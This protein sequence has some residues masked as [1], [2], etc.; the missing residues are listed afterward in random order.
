VKRVAVGMKFVAGTVRG[1]PFSTMAPF[2]LPRYFPK[3]AG[4]DTST[5]TGVPATRPF[6]LGLHASGWAATWR[7]AGSVI[8]TLKRLICQPG[9]GNPPG[10]NDTRSNP[11]SA[12][13]CLTQSAAAA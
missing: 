10:S 1:R 8:S 11:H 2:N 5:S 12:S 6:V 7:Y 4:D 13:L 3:S 9:P